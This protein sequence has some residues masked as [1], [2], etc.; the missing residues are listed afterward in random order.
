[1]SVGLEGNREKALMWRG[2]QIWI[3]GKKSEFSSYL[4]SMRFKLSIYYLQSAVD[5]FYAITAGLNGANRLRWR[6]FLN[7]NW[8]E[9]FLRE[10]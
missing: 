9:M 3:W 2:Y 7:Q 1:M 8:A 5:T 4:I 10:S 6:G